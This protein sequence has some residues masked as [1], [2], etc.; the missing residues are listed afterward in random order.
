MYR[1]IVAFKTS[2]VTFFKGSMILDSGSGP[3][4][5][6]CIGIVFASEVV[7]MGNPENGIA[8]AWILPLMR[9]LLFFRLK[10]C[11]DETHHFFYVAYTPLFILRGIP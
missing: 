6:P 11:R 1:K 2:H 3:Q 8:W 4:A 9:L 5:A 7:E 10:R